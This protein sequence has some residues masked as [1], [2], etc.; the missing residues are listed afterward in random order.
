MQSL[1]IV[2]EITLYFSSPTV[3]FIDMTHFN[4]DVCIAV[5][6]YLII[7][8]SEVVIYCKSAKCLYS[9]L[10]YVCLTD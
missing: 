5:F 3:F 4:M 1:I 2:R 8:A 7:L 9:L 6:H 10:F